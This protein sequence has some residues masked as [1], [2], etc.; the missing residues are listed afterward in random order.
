MARECGSLIDA[1]TLDAAQA[2]SR[3]HHAVAAAVAD[4]A[5]L[6][7][8]IVCTRAFA[9]RLLNLTAALNHLNLDADAVGKSAEALCLEACRSLVLN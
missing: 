7:V 5:A 3:W 4:D 6:F 8:R 2:A 1:A 9:A